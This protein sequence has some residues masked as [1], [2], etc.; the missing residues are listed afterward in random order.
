MRHPSDATAYDLVLRYNGTVC[1]CLDPVGLNQ[2]LT[3]PVHRGPTV[4]DI[5]L[6]LTNSYYLT[7][8]DARSGYQPETRKKSSYLTTFAWQ[9]GRYRHEITIQCNP[10]RGHVQG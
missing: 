2:A 6:S 10:S 8:I 3:R 5:F 4:I 9:F 7:L 1:M